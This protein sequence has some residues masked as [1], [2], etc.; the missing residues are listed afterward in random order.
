MIASGA[1]GVQPKFMASLGVPYLDNDSHFG[2]EDVSQGDEFNGT[3]FATTAKEFIPLLRQHIFKENNILFHMA[4]NVL[5]AADDAAV[6]DR[7]SEVEENRDLAGLH[8]R[9]ER[10]VARW[11]EEFK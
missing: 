2:G 3:K 5:S 4:A 7:L 6:N 10:E 9:Y 1:W 11:K 8:D